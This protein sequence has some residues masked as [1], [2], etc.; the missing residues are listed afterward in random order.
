MPRTLALFDV[1]GT[2]V[3]PPSTEVRFTRFLRE[4]GLLTWPRMLAYVLRVPERVLSA[5]T[6]ALKTNKAH[7]AGFDC[8]DLDALAETFLA[9]Q[10]AD[11]W[12]SDVRARLDA[13]R[14]RGD[15]VV[16]LTGTPDCV[17]AA[18]ARELGADG[19]EASALDRRKG[20]V[21]ARP[22]LQHPHG[23]VKLEI[24]RRL[25]AARGIRLADVWAYGD[26]WNDRHLLDAVGHPVAVHAGRRLQ[27]LARLKGW[28]RLRSAG[29]A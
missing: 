16:L 28:E 20:K 17:A 14:A 26:N 21:T 19:F 13:H 3:A 9:G 5:G 11:F 4:R 6:M 18:L 15:E 27:R 25:A 2:L 12:V 24:A 1:D 7:L 23:R 10:G 8:A 22:P 29:Q